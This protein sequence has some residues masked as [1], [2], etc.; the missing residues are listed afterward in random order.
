MTQASFASEGVRWNVLA[1]SFQ[2][3]AGFKV[4]NEKPLALDLDIVVENHGRRSVH[5]DDKSAPIERNRRQAHR[6]EQA[7]RGCD[8]STRT[9]N[10]GDFEQAPSEGSENTLFFSAQLASV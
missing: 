4:A 10:G 9:R 8:R 2:N 7:G 1:R 3:R 5:V 6:I